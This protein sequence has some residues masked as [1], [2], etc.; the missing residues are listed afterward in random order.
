MSSEQYIRKS[1]EAFYTE[2]G[3]ISIKRA[4]YCLRDALPAPCLHRRLES[5]TEFGHSPFSTI[6][7]GISPPSQ[8]PPPASSLSR[9]RLSSS[10]NPALPPSPL[11]R[12]A[13]RQ[14]GHRR[15]LLHVQR[16]RRGR[17]GSR[18]AQ[19][20]FLGAT[21]RLRARSHP[22]VLAASL[23]SWGRGPQLVP[24]A[25]VPS[26]HRGVSRPQNP[27]EP[28]ASAAALAPLIFA[29][30]SLVPLAAPAPIERTA[31]RPASGSAARRT[32]HR[33]LCA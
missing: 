23:S 18:R 15:P 2:A 4:D 29:I 12:Y 10:R 20:P 1:F 19:A 33:G 22:S 14:R 13:V 6:E 26:R 16:R 11:R 5:N 25:S 28:R 31:G 32:C 24:G 9:R 17:G 3:L 27:S 21:H 30:R 8:T 7:S